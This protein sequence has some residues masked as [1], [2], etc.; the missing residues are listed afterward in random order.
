MVMNLKNTCLYG[1]CK[2]FKK[3]GELVCVFE[4]DKLSNMCVL[5]D[6]HMHTHERRRM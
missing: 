1:Y 5:L 6:H 4:N 3:V 2:S